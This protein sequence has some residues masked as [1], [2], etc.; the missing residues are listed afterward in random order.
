M[1]PTYANLCHGANIVVY[2]TTKYIGGHGLSIGGLIVDGGNFNWEAA[3]DRF[4]MLNKP[5]PSY[6]GAVWSEAA[7]PLGP[8]AYILRARVILLRDYGSAMSPFNAFTFIQGL[9]T[10]VFRM[11]RH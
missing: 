2:S 7:K 11:Q 8:I 10:L 1:H 3:A 4:P 6:H 5:D 9:E